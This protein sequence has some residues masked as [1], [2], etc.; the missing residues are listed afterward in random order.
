MIEWDRLLLHRPNERADAGE[1]VRGHQTT[2]GK[3]RDG[4]GERI[5][6]D[7]RRSRQV[8]KERRAARSQHGQHA[9]AR[10]IE[11]PARSASLRGRI[12]ESQRV[13][14]GGVLAE[15]EREPQRSAAAP[16]RRQR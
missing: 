12:G 4:G 11:I 7:A 13:P 14:R 10:V 8:A 9:P 16:I 2:R 15:V 1:P 3:R 6:I 5:R